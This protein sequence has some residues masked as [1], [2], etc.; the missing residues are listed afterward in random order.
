MNDMQKNNSTANLRIFNRN[1]YINPK[2]SLM[3]PHL[4]S[5]GKFSGQSKKK[6]KKGE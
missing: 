2:K 5:Q 6:K 1:V 4:E 3:K